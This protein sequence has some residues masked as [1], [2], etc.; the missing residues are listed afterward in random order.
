MYKRQGESKIWILDD[1]E[2]FEQAYGALSEKPVSYTHL[3]VYKR[4]LQNY[5]PCYV[6]GADAMRCNVLFCLT[7]A[8]CQNYR[9]VLRLSLI[10]I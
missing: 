5:L 3:D 7:D 4:Q 2:G 8:Q 9:T 6:T 1:P 10:H